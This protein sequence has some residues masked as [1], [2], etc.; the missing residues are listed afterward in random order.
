MLHT[1]KIISTV[2]CTLLGSSLTCGLLHL[3]SVMHRAEIFFETWS[4]GLRGILRDCCCS[5]LH[6][7]EIVS[8]VCTE[9][10]SA[11]CCTPWSFFSLNLIP[12]T[13]PCVACC[14]DCL[15]E[16]ETKLKNTLARLSGAQMDWNQEKMEVENL[17]TYSL[18]SF[19]YGNR[20]FQLVVSVVF[21]KT[22]NNFKKL[23]YIH[24]FP[25]N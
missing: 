21:I 9:I 17:V 11:V 3:F 15:C 7:A 18:F 13:P 20:C 23:C 12:L 25:D 22:F 14:G 16:I 2:C 19:S 6:T 5:V 4:P 24:F 8:A 10:V 1:L